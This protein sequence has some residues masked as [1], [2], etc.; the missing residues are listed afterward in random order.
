MDYTGLAAM[1]VY[2]AS[3]PAGIVISGAGGVTAQSL[4]LPL[5]IGISVATFLVTA[6]VAWSPPADEINYDAA[7][8]AHARERS[9]APPNVTAAPMLPWS[10]GRIADRAPANDAHRGR[11]TPTGPA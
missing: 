4:L 3:G 10:I 1:R 7:L 8:L 5:V 11:V 2:P 6:A 9:P